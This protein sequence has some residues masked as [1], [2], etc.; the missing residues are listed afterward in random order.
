MAGAPSSPG[1]ALVVA[2]LAA[3]VVAGFVSWQVGER[4]YRAF[5]PQIVRPPNYDQMG[6]YEKRDFDAEAELDARP[7]AELKNAAVAFGALGAALGAALGLAAGLSRR[8]FPSAL[9]SG[10][11]GLV[12]GGVAGV[13]GAAAFVPVFFRFYDPESGMMLSLG[14]HCGL[15]AIT[16][17]GAGLALGMG[18]A[19][20]RLVPRAVIGGLFGGLAGAV[21]FELINAVAF[22]LVRVEETIP[23]DRYARLA[24]HLCVAIG[25]AAFAAIAATSGKAA[26]RNAE[27]PPGVA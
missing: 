19:H 4:A 3:G 18:L 13:A 5:L 6:T 9:A 23:A 17:A 1:R 2:A 12:V 25:V 7:A 27:M 21:M 22:P 15:W 10:A 16:G 26:T 8:A 20:R 24:A 11:A 14:V